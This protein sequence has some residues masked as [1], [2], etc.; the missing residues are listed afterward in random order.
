[1]HLHMHLH[2]SMLDFGP[3]YAFWLCSFER[4]NGKLKNIKMNCRNGLEVTFMRVFLEKA[5]ISTFL[6]AYSTNLLLP[7]I[8]FLESVAQVMLPLIMMKNA[9]Y[10][11]LFEFDVKT[12]Q[13]TSVS[14]YVVGRIPIGE[15]VFVNNWIQKVKKISLLGQEYCSGEKKKHG[16][17]FPAYQSSHHQ[18]LVEQGLELWEKGY[19]E[20]SSSCIVSVHRLHSCF[21]LA[22]Y[23]MQSEMQK[24][25]VIPLPRKVV[26]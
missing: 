17:F 9:H 13:S 21:A 1:M 14:F 25:L 7:M 23:K 5:F 15:D 4:Y 2:E 24:R 11:W 8:Q 26:T 22:T 18:L 20:E 16:S 19:M 6:H 3:V 10:Q 12:Y